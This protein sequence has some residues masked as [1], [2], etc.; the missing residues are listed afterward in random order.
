M[1]QR[2][3]GAGQAGLAAQV[4]AETA[5]LARFRERV[6]QPRQFA[7]RREVEVQQG[8]A[9]A[10][11]GVAQVGGQRV[12]QAALDAGRGGDAFALQ[13]MFATRC[14]APMGDDGF[15]RRAGVAFGEV[16]APADV[17]AA[18]RW[19][20]RRDVDA[21][22]AQH[23]LPCAIGSELRP[24][25]A[26]ESEHHGVCADLAFAFGRREAQ[27]VVF[28]PAE[29]AMLHVEA[30]ALC[31]QA[32]Y[33]A[34]QQRRCLEVGG[35]HATGTADEGVDAQSARPRAQGIGIEV[36]QPSG[37]F[38]LAF[39]IAPGEGRHRFG[40][41]EVEPTLAGDQELAPDRA[42]GVVQ[43]DLDAGSARDFRRHQPGGAAADDRERAQATS[44]AAWPDAHAHWK[45]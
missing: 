29:P 2:R 30:H 38:L 10:R 37:D 26:A 45:L 35:K 17:E 6:A 11:D 24:A 41:G 3:L 1:Q 4:F 42:L 40:M 9:V 12:D 20:Q 34:A 15:Q 28:A 39:A 22:I 5:A 8:A 14:I 19:L 43:V 27:R 44:P 21:A 18:V 36:A 31:V 25:A 13:L 7:S 33:P 16:R 23:V 32:A